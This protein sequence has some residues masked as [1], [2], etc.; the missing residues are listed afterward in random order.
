MGQ[1]S[2]YSTRFGGPGGNQTHGLRFCRPLPYHLATDPNLEQT[3]GI[4]PTTSSLP[5]TRTTNCSTSAKWSRRE[6]SNL[7]VVHYG[8]T[9]VPLSHIRE[10]GSEGW[11]RTSITGSKDLCPTVVRP[12]IKLEHGVGLEPT[13]TRFADERLGPLRHTVR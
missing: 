9:A 3:V 12:R 7:H 6:D 10:T 1:A 13:K 8:C 2:S 5:R 4:E 11:I